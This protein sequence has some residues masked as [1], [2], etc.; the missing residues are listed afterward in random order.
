[1]CYFIQTLFIEPN[2]ALLQHLL[3]KIRKNLK[4]KDIYG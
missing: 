3:L 4:T 1:M 2:N